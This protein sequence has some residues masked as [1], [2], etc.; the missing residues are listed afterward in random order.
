[1]NLFIKILLLLWIVSITNIL[2]QDC[3]A[4]I[5][6]S[7]DIEHI[8]ILIDDELVESS[9]YFEGSV[10]KGLHKITVY[11]NTG[12]W[13]SEIFIDT[14]NVLN[15]DDIHLE[16]NFRSNV[17]IDS[18]PGDANVFVGDSLIGY[19]PLFIPQGIN[20][21]RLE[22]KGYESRIISDSDIELNK[23]IQLNF[24]GEIST[25]S[26]V[27]KTLFK[28]LAGSML[29]LGAATAYYKLE[30]DDS[31]EEYEVTGD[32]SLLDRTDKFDTISGITF[33]AF[34]IN[35]GVLIYFFLVD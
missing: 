13:N 35:F 12:R 16:Y 6:I 19:T 30:A 15:C 3:D 9:K 23:P 26:F 32:P 27:D 31:F 34:Q 24:T 5:F 18:D 2:S 1:M 29:L 4:S 25:E 10:A 28:I 17:L 7:S 20:K 14:L 22:K 21:L 11:E 8:S 33:A